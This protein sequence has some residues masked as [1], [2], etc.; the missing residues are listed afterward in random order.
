VGSDTAGAGGAP[1]S[2]PA[3]SSGS[4]AERASVAAGAAPVAASL[5]QRIGV[6]THYYPHVHACV[7]A[8]E[9][10]EL[11]VGDTVHIR[12]HTTDYYQRVDRIEL[13]HRELDAAMPGQAVGLHVA[14][15][16]R[17]HDVVY[18]LSR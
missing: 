12:G 7:V 13:D 14:Q 11:R 5:P 2:G 1:A 17:E 15:R 9:E 4:A 8:M 10:G 6:V 18:R 16:V 3:A